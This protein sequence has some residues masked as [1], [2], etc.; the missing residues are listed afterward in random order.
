LAF[1]V[2]PCAAIEPKPKHDPLLD[3]SKPC[4]S[5]EVTVTGN[6]HIAIG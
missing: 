5:L 3:E 4:A 1:V 6:E 2:D